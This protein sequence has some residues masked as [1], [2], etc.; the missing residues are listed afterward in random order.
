MSISEKIDYW[1]DASDYYSFIDRINDK[2]FLLPDAE[3]DQE[4]VN[5]HGHL[6]SAIYYLDKKASVLAQCHIQNAYNLIHA[7]I[8]EA[9]INPQNVKKLYSLVNRLK[10][11]ELFLDC[12]DIMLN[13]FY[14][15]LIKINEKF[16]TSL[17]DIIYLNSYPQINRRSEIK[18]INGN[19]FLNSDAAI[20]SINK[21]AH[22]H[23]SST[24][25][26]PKELRKFKRNNLS[27][28]LFLAMTEKKIVGF[29]LNTFNNEFYVTRFI[30]IETELR[31]KDIGTKLLFRTLKDAQDNQKNTVSL[32]YWS[33]SS[34]P[35]ENVKCKIRT[36]FYNNLFK[37]GVVVENASSVSERDVNQKV[38]GINQ[39]LD[40]LVADFNFEASLNHLQKKKIKTKKIDPRKTFSEEKKF[41]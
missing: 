33:Y 12:T 17:V 38:C 29:V 26:L 21:I 18:I 22:Q 34:D 35:V 37:Y 16:K 32:S 36:L 40:L 24:F 39:N 3:Y 23:F 13:E 15:L 27:Y 11:V 19:Y 6:K 20:G 5:E 2:E 25:H 14:A 8:N 1:L 41:F 9:S 7:S 28:S 30:A 31:G 4:I 10:F